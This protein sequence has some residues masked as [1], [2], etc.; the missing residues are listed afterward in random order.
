MVHKKGFTAKFVGFIKSDPL[1]KPFTSQ[2]EETEEEERDH[3]FKKDK[4]VDSLGDADA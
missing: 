1:I 2:E 4:P 3:Y